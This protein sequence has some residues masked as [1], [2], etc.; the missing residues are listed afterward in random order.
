MMRT[1]QFNIFVASCSSQLTSRFRSFFSA[2]F[3]EARIYPSFFLG[4][5]RIRTTLFLCLVLQ[6]LRGNNRVYLTFCRVWEKFLLL[7]GLSLHSNRCLHH[8]SAILPRISTLIFYLQGSCI[9]LYI[10]IIMRLPFLRVTRMKK[11]FNNFHLV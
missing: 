7:K 8:S 3:F 1:S 2:K 11:D 9:F 4:V 10:R 5:E 6:G